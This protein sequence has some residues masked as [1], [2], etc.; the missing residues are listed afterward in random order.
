MLKIPL[1]IKFNT[2]F[3]ILGGLRVRM[4]CQ[5]G[6]HSKKVI[7]PYPSF[8]AY[9]PLQIEFP[10][11]F[12]MIFYGLTGLTHSFRPKS[13][14]VCP[15][16]CRKAALHALV[17]ADFFEDLPRFDCVLQ[18]QTAMGAINHGIHMDTLEIPSGELT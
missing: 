7:F 13:N 2:P 4:L 10:Y 3:H 15:T 14:R 11:V 18:H 16:P 12:P 6:D 8:H 5:G 1:N 17:V 9:F